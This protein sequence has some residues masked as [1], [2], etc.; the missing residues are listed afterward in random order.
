MAKAYDRARTREYVP[1]CDRELPPEQQTVFILGW[2]SVFDYTA[3][4]EMFK[5]VKDDEKIFERLAEIARR[6]IRGWRRFPLPDGSEA[7]FEKGS[8]NVA[9]RET[10]ERIGATEIVEIATDVGLNEKLTPDDVGK[11]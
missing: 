3:M 5:D 9:T 11:S 4:A 7:P 8:D 6:A 1:K 10:L 2:L